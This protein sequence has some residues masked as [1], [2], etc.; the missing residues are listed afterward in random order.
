MPELEETSPRK[1][2]SASGIRSAPGI[3]AVGR[4]QLAEACPKE[5]AFVIITMERLG[6]YSLLQPRSF[7]ILF[8]IHQSATMQIYF[9]LDLFLPVYKRIASPHGF[10]KAKRTSS[11]LPMMRDGQKT[12]DA[13]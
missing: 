12:V 7:G 2:A 3:E 1:G 4:S 5:V 9:G 13:A 8:K 6:K 11:G 10:G